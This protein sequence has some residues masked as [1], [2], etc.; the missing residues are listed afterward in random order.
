MK[1]E[2]EK[3][4]HVLKARELKEEENK[5]RALLKDDRIKL[6]YES[7]DAVKEDMRDKLD[8]LAQFI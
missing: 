5:K 2:R 8:E 7:V 1:E 3:H 4:L 6:F